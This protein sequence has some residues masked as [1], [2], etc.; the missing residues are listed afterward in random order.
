MPLILLYGKTME[1]KEFL[2]AVLGDEGYYCIVGIKEDKV[3]HKFVTSLTEAE[4]EARNFDDSG[5]D[6]YFSL[7]TFKNGDSRKAANS[8]QIKSLFIDLDCGVGKPY[9]T[10]ADGIKALREFRVKYKLPAFTAVVNSGR[11]L[12]VYWVL[13]RAYSKEEW[14]P[15]AIRL[16]SACMDFG[17]EIDRTVSADAARILRVPNT[18]NFKGDPPLDVKVINKELNPSVSLDVFNEN[19]PDNILTVSPSEYS[20][21]DAKD[22]AR[23]MGIDK[24]RKRFGKL[25]EANA[26]G[27]G[28]AQIH[29]AITK[30]NDLSYADWLHVLSIAKYCDVDGDKAI[31]LISKGYDRYSP[32]ETD[33][34]AASIETPHL[35]S[36]FEFDN[37]EG[38]EGC[39]H[40]QSGKIR[41]PIK[42]CMEIREAESAEVVVEVYDEQFTEEGTVNS[43]EG[44]DSNDEEGIPLP[45]PTK[46][47]TVKIPEYPFPYK[48]AASGGI[49]ISVEKDDGT[50]Y[51]ETIYK[52]PLY[53]T[54][55]LRDPFE[56]P[57]FEFK[58]HTDREGIQTF[59][60]PMSDLTSKEQFR[61]VM[62]KNDI[63]V[64]NKQADAL[65]V[66]VGAWINKLQGKDGQDF[67]DV[68][69]Q[70]G[71]TEDMKAFVIGEREIRANEITI[72]PASSRTAQYFPM[73]RKKGTLEGWKHVTK[74]YNKDGFEE[75][76]FMFGLSFGAP[77]MQFIPNVA[78]AIY[79][80][81]ST[82]TGY[83]KTTGML[84]GASVWGNHK[85]LV[86]RGKD[87]GNSAWNRAEIWKNMVLYIDEITN[88]KPEPASEF[89]YGACDGEQKNRLSSSGQNEERYRG[90]EWAL[91]VG[92]SGNTSL[93]E[94]VSKHRT[95]AKGEFGRMLE[96]VASK[97]L[98]SKAQTDAA[99]K[100]N[101]DLAKNYGH[102]GEIYIQHILN[103]M[104]SVEKQVL[105]TRNQLLQDAE[106]D[107]QHRFWVA[108][109]AV[110]FSGLTIAKKIGLLDWN[111][112]ALYD[113]MV[114]KLMLAKEDLQA[115][116][117]DVQDLV[118]Q[119]LAEHPRGILRVRSTD[120]A[121][122][123]DPQKQHLIMPDAVPLYQWVGRLEYD[124][125]RLYLVPAPFKEWCVKRGHHHNG[126]R[127][128]LTKYMGAQKVRMRLGKGTK[129]KTPLQ[130]LLMV[131]WED[132]ENDDEVHA[133]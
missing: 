75:H 116:V 50:T 39:P 91:L 97:K 16:K 61:K 129:L 81:M 107:S 115:M 131:E 109:T 46:T 57:S 30:P 56:G 87:T 108:Q 64:L 118:A 79:H 123:N 66:Y 98:T 10:Q 8:L 130:H 117:V 95:H 125:N 84:A 52:R 45:P 111:L 25:L 49:Y 38:C 12:H 124:I 32:E 90:A 17:L 104:K 47:Q 20:S 29:R 101:D 37:P 78:G 33:K 19:L 51:E 4:Q 92:T 106:L 67:V 58:H 82:D 53:I 21:E 77:L 60:I 34:I 41:S 94:I 119:Y 54:K 26:A 2:E 80:L 99:N 62:G 85:K 72:N 44:S 122:T 132:G 83:G 48:R 105:D 1:T 22:M 121:R 59:V 112:E 28:C 23:A 71:W 69:T 27:N 7:S 120:D 35:C 40:K 100:L 102:A 5:F 36:T 103:N 96:V 88:Y 18:H 63:F 3:I 114:Q 93:Q 127:E 14:K 74:F 89:V 55:R 13:D 6:A 128:L 65:M 86:L 76:Q 73:F 133:D 43:S 70:F 11:G 24:Y 9:A 68:R 110:V 126:V 42:L 31:H 113:W 15:V